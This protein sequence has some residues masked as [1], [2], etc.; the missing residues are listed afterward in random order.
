MLQDQYPLLMTQ[1]ITGKGIDRTFMPEL[2][3]E[4]LGVKVPQ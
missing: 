2:A 1:T 3:R 4:D